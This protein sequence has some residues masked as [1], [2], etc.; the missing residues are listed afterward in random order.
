MESNF[1]SWNTRIFKMN[2]DLFFKGERELGEQDFKTNLNLLGW[3]IFQTVK[4]K[5]LKYILEIVLSISQN[6]YINSTFQVGAFDLWWESCLHIICA[7]SCFIYSFSKLPDFLSFGK[8]IV[9]SF[10]TQLKVKASL[11]DNL[12]GFCHLMYA[13]SCF[14]FR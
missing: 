8:N 10:Q 9:W 14:F 4:R 1:S 7:D 6:E 12:I 5:L 13:L 11:C 3:N 2:Y